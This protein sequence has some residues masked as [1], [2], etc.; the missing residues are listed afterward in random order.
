[1]LEIDDITKS[2]SRTWESVSQGWRHLISR[3]ENALTRFSSEDDKKDN[4][5]VQ[6]PRWGLMSLDMFDDADKLVIKL[7]VPGLETDD[8]DITVVD[9]MLTVSGQK[10]FQREQTK[11]EYRV[12][13]CAY[14]QFTRCIPLSYEVDAES[15][16]ASYD[17]GVLK[18]ELQ[19]TPNQ[20]RRKIVIS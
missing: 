5:P 20:R 14:G 15:A 9:N 16:K 1:M 19:K 6:S 8:F 7:E 10:R 18:I 13:E 2:L 11:G 12:L 17:K 3:A 4:I